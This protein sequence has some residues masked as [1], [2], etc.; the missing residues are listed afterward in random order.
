MNAA[1]LR[2]SLDALHHEIAGFLSDNAEHAKDHDTSTLILA[3]RP[4]AA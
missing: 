2:T 4:R 3:A 1:T